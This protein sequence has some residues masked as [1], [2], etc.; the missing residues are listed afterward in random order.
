VCAYCFKE[1]THTAPN[2]VSTL[3]SSESFENLAEFFGHLSDSPT[4]PKEESKGK[5][6]A[7][8]VTVK[9]INANEKG[10]AMVKGKVLIPQ[11]RKAQRKGLYNITNIVAN[12]G[13]KEEQ[14]GNG[15]SN[16]DHNPTDN[17]I[18]PLSSLPPLPTL[19]TQ[20]RYRPTNLASS[21]SLTPPLGHIQH[22]HS[23]SLRSNNINNG[24]TSPHAVSL[25]DSLKSERRGSID[26]IDNSN[27][28]T[29]ASEDLSSVPSMEEH[30]PSP[31]VQPRHVVVG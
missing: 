23:P 29:D 24:N 12:G 4:P 31:K 16:V 5:N 20:P 9:R 8:T 27:S 11:T 26:S 25:D 30:N 3:H 18:D 22:N 6:G 14:N 7:V 17:S 19:P 2:S 21:A 1:L 28:F 15:T 10:M 13:E